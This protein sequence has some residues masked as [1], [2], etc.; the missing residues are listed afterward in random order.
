VLSYVL[1]AQGVKVPH[2]CAGEDFLNIAIV[3]TFLRSSGAFFMKRSFKDDPLYKS[4]FTEYVHSLLA[5]THSL[6]F[7]LEGTRARSGKTMKPKFGLLNILTESYFIE[8]V[9]NLHFVPVTI[10]YSR[11]LEGETF[12]LEI[13][14]E[15]KVKESLS[16]IINAT[17]YI[18]MNFGAI[19]IQ[20]AEPINFKNYI[21]E[22][23]LKEG[24]NPTLNKEDQKLITSSLGYALTYRIMDNLIIMPTSI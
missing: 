4:I 7:F 19:Y 18:S 16:R 3:H 5:D 2:I 10:N 20:V 8:K 23:S 24:L 12:P 21:Q 9:Q 6:E 13:L 17:R 15:S 14:G 11:V 22:M 1:Y